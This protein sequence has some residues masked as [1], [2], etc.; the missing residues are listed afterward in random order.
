[1]SIMSKLHMYARTQSLEIAKNDSVHLSKIYG[2]LYLT[3][4]LDESMG[5]PRSSVV[6]QLLPQRAQVR[7]MD[8]GKKKE[9][10]EQKKREGNETQGNR[11]GK[12]RQ[13]EARKG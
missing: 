1:M 9:W 11:D 13:R 4:T 5:V 8:K 2:H 6:K 3:W 7:G 12:L 10:Q